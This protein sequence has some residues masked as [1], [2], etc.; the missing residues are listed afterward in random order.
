MVEWEVYGT[1]PTPILTSANAVTVPEGGT[2][3]FQVKLNT[4]SGQPHDGDRQ[5]GQRGHGYH[6]AVGRFAGVQRLQLEHRPDGDAGG[7]GRRG[8]GELLGDHPVQ[9][10]RG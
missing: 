7:G 4:A 10:D 1:P 8:H 3:T 9:R 2:A 6:R 5:P